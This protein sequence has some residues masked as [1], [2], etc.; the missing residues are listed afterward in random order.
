MS[1]GLL[2]LEDIYKPDGGMNR[3]CGSTLVDE[4]IRGKGARVPRIAW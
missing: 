2:I 4:D 1:C 3:I